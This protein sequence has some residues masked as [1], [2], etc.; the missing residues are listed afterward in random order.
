M[1]H[2]I[3]MFISLKFTGRLIYISIQ[4]IYKSFT[5][6]F[7]YISPIYPKI[8]ISHIFLYKSHINIYKYTTFTYIL[9]ICKGDLFGE[10]LVRDTS[11]LLFVN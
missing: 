9:N 1:N 8:Y 7:I 11:I 5:Y 2:I 6:T 10:I 4:N 3:M